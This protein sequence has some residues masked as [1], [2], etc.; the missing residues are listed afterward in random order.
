MIR[1]IIADDIQIIRE[2]L[3]AVLSQDKEIKVVALADDGR[4]AYLKCKR[5]TPDIVIMDMRMPEFDGEYGIRKIKENC[6]QSK[7]LVLTTFDDDETISKAILNGADGYILKEMS[8]E[9][10]INSIKAVNMGMNIFCSN[11]YSNIRTKLSPDVDEIV[12]DLTEREID[13]LR[14]IAKGYDNKTIATKLFIAE[15][16]VRNNVSKMLEKLNYKDRTQL[17]VFAVKNNIL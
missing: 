9:K 13:V 8:D 10:I 17:A 14:L 16:T 5:L 12:T 6:P 3:E 2:S 1:V 15:G 4:E 11:V 7:I